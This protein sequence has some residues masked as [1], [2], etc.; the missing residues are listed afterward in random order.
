MIAQRKEQSQLQIDYSLSTL[1]LRSCVF[2]LSEKVFHSFSVG[3]LQVKEKNRWSLE[4]LLFAARCKDPLNAVRAVLREKHREKQWAKEHRRT[5]GW[6]RSRQ[7]VM[8]ASQGRIKKSNQP[9]EPA[10]KCFCL[11]F[12]V[13][14]FL[15]LHYDL[16]QERRT[17][18]RSGTNNGFSSENHSTVSLFHFA[19]SYRCNH[20]PRF[21]KNRSRG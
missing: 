2:F 14:I 11:R 16:H 13:M 12:L 9:A 4:D 17:D 10:P 19:H 18:T 20:Q 7:V 1:S 21:L 6:R 3:E 15:L 8:H 5:Q